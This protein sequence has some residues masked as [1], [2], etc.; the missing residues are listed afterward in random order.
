MKT[1]KETKRAE[2]IEIDEREY[3]EKLTEIY[4]TINICGMT[5]DAG[6]AL[7]EL[8]PTAFRCGMADEPEQWKCTEC[9]TIHDSEEEAEECCKED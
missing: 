2:L 4:G 5:F 8:D 7:K 3:Q 9:D 6:Y 1:E